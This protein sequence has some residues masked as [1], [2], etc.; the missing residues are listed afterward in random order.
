MH[1]RDRTL[2]PHSPHSAP[3]DF[4]PLS[5]AKS[6]L[7]R[8]YFQAADEV[9]SKTAD[10]L[11]RVRADHLQ[12]RFEQWGILMQRCTATLKGIENNL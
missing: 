5:K 10:L 12:H 8:N 2:P 7:K 11:N 1:S 3:C 4:Y 9:E 6:A